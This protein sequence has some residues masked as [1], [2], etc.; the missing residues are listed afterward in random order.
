MP[1]ANLPA[2]SFVVPGTENPGVPL[3]Y[4]V[5][6]SSE[7]DSRSRLIVSH[8]SPSL[9]E[10]LW[11]LVREAKGDDVLSPVTVI[12][13][14]RYAN[15]SLRHELG[16][17]GFVNVRFVVMPVLLEQLGAALLA[18]EGRRPLTTAL[19]TV[20]VRSVLADSTGPLETVKD[21]PSTQAS[22][23]QAFRE[24]R[25]SGEPLLTGLERNLGTSALVAQLFRAFRR[26]ITAQ[27]YDVEDLASVAA[28]VV[29]RMDSRDL[30]ELGRIIF[31][32]PRNMTPS[33]TRLVQALARR[34]SCDVMLGITSDET[35][36]GPTE[37][38]ADSL[39]S[40]FGTSP[41]A[42][43][44]SDGPSYVPEETQ[45]HIA[46]SAHEELRWVIR[47]I[48][49][50]AHE[51]KTPFHQMAVLYR[52]ESP[53]ASL[54]PDEL[55]M[56]GIPVAGP[57]KGTLAETGVGRTLLGILRLADGQFRRSDVMTWLTGAPVQPP[58]GRTAGFNPSYWDSLT[59]KAG[60]V[61]DL[62]QWRSRLRLYAE[63]L[64][65]EAQRGLRTE[66]IAENR[67]DRMRYEATAA[68]QAVAFIER[69][70]EDLEPPAMGS[71]W[72]AFSKWAK[73]ALEL[74]LSHELSQSETEA[75]RKVDLLL[76]ELQSADSINASTTLEVFRQTMEESLRVP[77]GQLGP[78]GAGVFVSTFALSAG[79]NFAAVWMV[80]MIEGGVP[81]SLRPDP[82][83]PESAWL[84][85]GGES[86][87]AQR[88][89]TERYDYLSA[90]AS[91]PR[92]TLSYP[93][94]D[95]GASRE[96]YP[97]RWF[98]EQA[99]ILEG[100]RVYASDVGSLRGRP[101]LS[102][103]DSGEH[104]LSDVPDHA[105][106]DVHDYRLRRLLQW[107]QERR[108][109]GLH[110]LASEGRISGAISLSRA[111]N[112]DHWSEYDGNLTEVAATAIFGANLEQ[113]AISATRLE[114]WATC[115]FRYFLGQVLRIGSLE[116][117]EE[118]TRISS[119]DRGL[120]VHE[121]LE[122]F[123]AESVRQGELPGPG[124]EWMGP[125]KERLNKIT[126]AAFRDAENRGI[127][128]KPLLWRLDREEIVEDLESFLEEEARLR[129]GH[130][131]AEVLAETRFGFGDESA[132]VRDQDTQVRFRGYIDRLDISA[133]G[134][135]VLVIDYKTGSTRPYEGLKDD[136][137]DQGRRLQL[138]VYSLA[139]QQLVPGATEVR[140]AYWFT[141]NGGGFQLSPPGYFDIND[142]SMRERFQMGVS[143]VVA[144]IR[145][146][147]FPANPGPW[148]NYG[149]GE[150]DYKNCRYCD[151]NSLCPARRAEIWDRKKSDPRLSDYLGLSNSGE[152]AQA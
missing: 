103:D 52:M 24:L 11:Q 30:D 145:G 67:A 19:E 50:E 2:A 61:G 53:Y 5:F 58:A 134:A 82:M 150:S 34:G 85:T 79:M 130:G 41:A 86:R 90:L 3:W 126:N 117:P 72:E 88:A 144:G 138:G 37:K 59:R 140:A 49:R 28:D 64:E 121:I 38:L 32:L 89:A 131:S 7:R 143:T 55:A 21:H 108:R 124:E 152:A 102:V 63:G 43:Q 92:R 149:A 110:P 148:T 68:R 57:A 104:A 127:T 10:T 25:R 14:T 17:D 36:D 62:T 122:E 47:Q 109:L 4:F 75:K 16:R 151:F 115:P 125:S 106:A 27:W 69:L 48:V 83:L 13:P 123:I 101:W 8:Q 94:A 84:E 129:A 65:S 78:T 95:G 33:E 1:R 114:S 29:D 18:R 23:R 146:G 74:Y 93:V 71:S 107:R 45:L 100:S 96:A 6:M 80:G 20:A 136:I 119:L 35:A 51:R 73:S 133:D 54:I 12:G 105:L 56:A 111:R 42:K 132:E 26:D 46:P 15:L 40:S 66:E 81:P 118:I 99:S 9:R 113:S 91:A 97:S 76:D 70:A 77:V 147:K 128:G 87:S 135:S 60:V 142:A 22:I 112:L 139:A 98:L 141:T 120:L 116:T 44:G 31:Y 137:I 39:R